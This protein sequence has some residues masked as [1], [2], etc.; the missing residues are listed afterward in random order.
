MVAITGQVTIRVTIIMSWCSWW[1]IDRKTLYLCIWLES[2]T[3]FT[4]D[5]KGAI[6]PVTFYIPSKIHQ[7]IC[8]NGCNSSYLETRHGWRLNH[9]KEFFSSY[10]IIRSGDFSNPQ[11]FYFHI[12]SQ[13]SSM[14]GKT[15][16]RKHF[17]LYY[18]ISENKSFLPTTHLSKAMYKSGHN[19]PRH[20]YK[21][22]YFLYAIKIIHHWDFWY[23]I[24]PRL[25]YSP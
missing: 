12:S 9:P 7:N 4:M 5:S 21:I 16:S 1:T 8:Y 14:Q 10:I 25:A 6:M 13:S 3:H 20:G 23:L 18:Y 24:H 2:L 19:H 22:R 17:K 11:R 15:H